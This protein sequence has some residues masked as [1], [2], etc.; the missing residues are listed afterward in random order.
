MDLTDKDRFSRHRKNPQRNLHCV[1]RPGQFNQLDKSPIPGRKWPLRLVPLPNNHMSPPTNYQALVI[2]LGVSR[3][4]GRPHNRVPHHLLPRRERV[5]HELIRQ[6]SCNSSRCNRLCLKT[7]F[8]WLHLESSQCVDLHNLMRHTRL[9]Y[10]S[11]RR[12][13][14]TI[15][16]RQVLKAAV[17]EVQVVQAVEVVAVVAVR[18]VALEVAVAVVEGKDRLHSA[19]WIHLLRTSH[20]PIP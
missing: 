18:K 8:K 16:Y 19:N 3:L 10:P 14:S 11:H 2:W 5:F 9:R 20:L 15:G 13:F 12:S 17:E 4:R 1:E 7:L 6:M